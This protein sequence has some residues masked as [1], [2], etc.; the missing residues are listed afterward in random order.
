MRKTI[1]ILAHVDAGKTTFSEQLLACCGALRTPGRVDHGDTLLDHHPLERARGITIFADQAILTRGE[2]RLYWLDT[3]GH[4][5]FIAEAERAMLAMDYAVLL[6]SCPDGLPSHTKTLWRLAADHSLPV[7]LF[8]NKTDLPAA[9]PEEALRA[10][11]GR[12]TPD[13]LDLRGVDPAQPLPESV[14]EEIALRDEALFNRYMECDPVSDSEWR[15]SLQRLIRGRRVFPLMA[16]SALRGDGVSAFIE[17]LLRFTQTDYDGKESA[18]LSAVCYRVRHEQGQRI[19]HLKL[20]SGQLSPRQALPGR[21]ERITELR[22]FHG[23]KSSALPRALA[24]DLCAVPGLPGLRPGDWL[25]E[26]P[27]PVAA[28]VP[29]LESDLVWDAGAVPAFRMLERLRELEEEDPSLQVRAAGERLSLRVSGRLQLE[30]LS[31]LIEERWGQRVSFGPARVLYRETI[32]APAVGIGHYEPLRHYAEVHLRLLPGEPGS[33]IRFVSRCSVDA[34][35]LN[36]QRLIET[37][38]FEREH[39]GVLTG[40][41]LADVVVELLGGRAHLKHTEGGDFRQA[42]GRAIRCALMNARSVLLEPICRYEARVPGDQA[43][44]VSASLAQ[45]RTDPEPPEADGGEVLLR[46]EAHLAR[47]AA[48]QD[49]FPALTHGRG[50]LTVSFTRYAPCEPEEQERLIAE[51]GY[52]PLAEDTPDS[53]FCSHGAGYTVAWNRVPDFA[54]VHPEGEDT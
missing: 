8:L 42:T 52:N 46:G 30:I 49:G 36:W 11:R 9:D 17:L 4:P 32:A 24:G 13:V 47:F 39:K 5:D 10:L 26:H 54:H 19:C 53:V 16:G 18:P 45:L 37:H 33:G 2:D 41:P 7:F 14:C 44:R 40:A 38:V 35:A 23:A 3:P 15:A 12:L 28:S 21:E 34:L 48:W 25:G 29:L 51:S 6:I 1:G 22:A 31:A 50:Q 27:A 20:F 43:G